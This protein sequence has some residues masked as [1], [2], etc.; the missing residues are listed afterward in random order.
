M[1]LKSSLLGETREHEV[2]GQYIC[3]LTGEGRF[4]V[5]RERKLVVLGGEGFGV[6]TPV[7]VMVD[8]K[9]VWWVKAADPARDGGFAVLAEYYTYSDTSEGEVEVLGRS[10]LIT[11][12]S[13]LV[14]EET[15]RLPPEVRVRGWRLQY[16]GESALVNVPDRSEP[17]GELW[18][19][20]CGTGQS[21][22][23][24]LAGELE[25]VDSYDVH[26]LEDGRPAVVSG[27]RRRVDFF[28][29]PCAEE[30]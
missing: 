18:L 27:C 8:D 2:Q 23:L 30:K 6:E 5:R 24:A 13:D 15:V 12:N 29:V 19:V 25:G 11:F 16:D 20:N 22:K 28:R 26:L 4:L 3:S 10:A 21:V 1:R 17:T 9:P 7:E 14:A